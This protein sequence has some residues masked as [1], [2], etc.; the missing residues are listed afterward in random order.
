MPFCPRCRCEYI[1]GVVQCPDCRA[2][3]VEALPSPTPPLQVG[4]TEVE[5]C[6]IDGEIHAKLLQ[7]ILAREGIASRLAPAQ[8]LSPAYILKAP[9][10]VGGGYDEA[11]RIMVKQSEFARAQVI[12]DDYEVDASS[13]GEARRSAAE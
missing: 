5:L 9:W 1:A 2:E 3:L 13:S 12:R 8:P 11:F 7:S 6:T 4:F 10:P